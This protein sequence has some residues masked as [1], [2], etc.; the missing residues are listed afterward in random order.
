MKCGPQPNERSVRAWFDGNDWIDWGN[1]KVLNAYNP[2]TTGFLKR[3]KRPDYKGTFK[4]SVSVRTAAS[5]LLIAILEM[6]H[7]QRPRIVACVDHGA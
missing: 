1:K 6:K 2:P 5:D 3:P 4:F 7:H